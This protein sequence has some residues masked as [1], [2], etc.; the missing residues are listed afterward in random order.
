MGRAGARP[1]ALAISAGSERVRTS[2]GARVRRPVRAAP[3]ASHRRSLVP[4]EAGVLGA[5]KAGVSV[6]DHG[7]CEKRPAPRLRQGAVP[8]VKTLGV[9]SGLSE[10][11][12]QDEVE[13]H[14]VVALAMGRV[15][16]SGKPDR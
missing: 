16:H 9:F 4:G 2:A 13:H 3:G 15:V 14:D 12:R 6:C 10:A 11:S 1:R 8:P 7:L 5:R